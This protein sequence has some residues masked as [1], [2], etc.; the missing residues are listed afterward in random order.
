MP[1][2][3]A[4]HLTRSLG[5][6]ERTVTA[7][8]NARLIPIIK[9]LLLSVK[10]V[11]AEKQI[12]AAIMVVKG[13]GS[14]MGETQA[15][16]KPIETL[17]SGPASSIIGATFLANEKDVMVLDMGGTTTDIAILRNGIPRINEEGAQVGGWLTRVEAADICAYGLGGDSYLQKDLNGSFKVGPQR[18]WPISVLSY[19]YPYLVEELDNSSLSRSYLLLYS[20]ATDC[21]MILN[22]RETVTLTES[23]RKILQVLQDGPHS[24]F[25]IIQA[26]E[27]ELNLIDFSRLVNTGVLGRISVTPTD[28]LHAKGDYTQ[29]NVDG[30]KA[31]VKL[32]ATRFDMNME[33][34]IKW[35]SALIV[36]E[37][38]YACLQSISNY[39]GNCF[40]LKE[41]AVARYFI[42]K[43]LFNGKDTLLTCSM[44]PQIPIIGIGA[45]VKAWLPLMA[46]K[47]DA[48]LVTPKNPEVANAVGSA[49]G[50]IMETVKILINPGEGSSGGAPLHLGTKIFR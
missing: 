25:Y 27:S 49:T 14:L 3:C 11:L 1:V 6:H 22:E 39:E 21:F 30:A 8:L 42:E 35:A 44:K 45:P 43:Q 46:E 29:W 48:R 16:D 12:K 26:L 40:S 36:D 20:Q 34:F 31:A 37:L 33:E 28:I 32:L 2:V 19:Y 41:Q 18:V 47:L 24:L 15:E 23:E 13:D 38:C 50:K 9:D 5:V 17:L 4:H 7:I 10:K